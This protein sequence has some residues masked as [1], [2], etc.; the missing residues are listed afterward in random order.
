MGLKK[1]KVQLATGKSSFALLDSEHGLV[2]PYGT[3]M[4]QLSLSGVPANTLEAKASDLKIFF[5]YLAAFSNAEEV[6]AALPNLDRNFLSTVILDFPNYLIFGN[7]NSAVP[8]AWFAATKNNRIPIATTSSNRV[9]STVN[10]LLKDSALFHSSLQS[11]KAQGIVNID[12]SAENLFDELLQRKELSRAERQAMMSRSVLAGVIMGGAKYSDSSLFKSRVRTGISKGTGAYVDKAL[13]SVEAIQVLD[14]AKC[15]RDRC[16]W[17]FLLGTGARPN[18][19]LTLLQQD[20]DPISST[21]RL[22]DPA[23]RPLE[24]VSLS[25][26]ENASH[27]GREVEEVYFIEPFRTYFF[28]SLQKYLQHERKPFSCDHNFLFIHLKGPNKGKPQIDGDMKTQRKAFKDA[29]RACGGETKKAL[30]ACRHFYGVYCRNFIPLGN[31]RFGFNE[32]TVQLMMGHKKTEST[33][34]YT[35][36][37]SYL[38]KAKLDHVNRLIEEQGISFDANK[39][40]KLFDNRRGL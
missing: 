5:E 29:L 18:E 38:L 11:M 32:N 10:G 24:Y 21:V 17:S 33:Q 1:I 12:V 26:P 30:H 39:E 34:V 20:V 9:K 37:P 22:V 6:A 36:P 14:E 15:Y 23:T 2:E 13:T 40:M 35:L 19:G 16:Y 7:K 25:N 8:V 27:K 28:E 31:D 4:D 3:Y